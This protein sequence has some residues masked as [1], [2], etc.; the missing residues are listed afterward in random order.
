MKS[1]FVLVASVTAQQ[2]YDEV[3]IRNTINSLPLTCS[4]S[5]RLQNV[6]NKFHLFSQAMNYG[7]GSGQ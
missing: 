7:T 3:E 4:S 1:I 2:V 5:I 6:A